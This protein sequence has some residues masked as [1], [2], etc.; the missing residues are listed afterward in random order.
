[1]PTYEINTFKKMGEEN[2]SNR[3]IVEAD[4]E[5]A[6]LS[7]ADMLISA[8]RS[9]HLSNVLFTYVRASTMLAGDRNFFVFPQNTIGSLIPDGAPE[10]LWNCVRVDFSVAGGGSPSR[11]F[12]RGVLSDGVTDGVEFD[13]PL[14]TTMQGVLN[15]LISDLQSNGILFQDPD[16][17]AIL[18]AFPYDKIVNRKL[19]RRRR[20]KA[21]TTP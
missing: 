4:D 20:K 7:A 6:L 1:V 9:F 11:K 17:Q 5:A 3:Y 13:G 10:P 19:H 8:E 18:A 16:G 15:S 21:T 2:W 12:Y 14:R